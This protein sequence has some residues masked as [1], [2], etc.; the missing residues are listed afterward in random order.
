M[1][2]D[3][4]N[5]VTLPPLPPEQERLERYLDGLMD[6]AERAAFEAEI[7]SDAAAQL[8]ITA[9]RRLAA[10]LGELY[11]TTPA[12]SLQG[13]KFPAAATAGLARSR[14]L[15]IAGIAAAVAVVVG[16]AIY[17]LTPQPH[18]P[19]PKFATDTELQT[20]NRNV[21]VKEYQAQVASGFVP[22]EVCTTDKQFQEWTQKAFGQSLTPTHLAS[23]STGPAEPVL[24]GWSRATIFSG[25]S[26]LLLA[27]VDGKPVMVVMDHA[28][29]RMVPKDDATSSPR[30]FQR[31]VGDVWLI[32]ITPLDTP[33][34]VT[35][36]ENA[37][38]TPPAP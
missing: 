36:I 22:K 12:T 38:A 35:M 19:E 32:E 2:N 28:P 4:T 16:G 31:K 7:K 21:I 13:L 15:R 18:V 11:D 25:Y 1:T 5:A 14:L 6:A 33:R 3:D 9:H 20:R 10:A 27:H 17:F 24:A 29:D 26:G 30:V 34:V 8:Q 37:P 23:G